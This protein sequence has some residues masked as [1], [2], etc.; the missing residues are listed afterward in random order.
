MIHYLIIGH[1]A[2]EEAES[3]VCVVQ[4]EQSNSYL[5]KKF[6]KL[7]R[8]DWHYDPDKEIY[9]DFILESDSLIHVNY[10]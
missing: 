5:E 4:D 8:E 6:I 2:F 1:A 9:V 7:I 10:G 3:R